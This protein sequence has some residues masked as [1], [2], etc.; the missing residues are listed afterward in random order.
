MATSIVPVEEVTMELYSYSWPLWVKTPAW[1]AA[2]TKSYNLKS[3]RNFEIHS[4]I[5]R[6]SSS[7]LSICALESNLEIQSI[8]PIRKCIESLLYQILGQNRSQI[9]LIR[10]KKN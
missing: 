2:K 1:A 6:K 7:L 5:L 4:V 8:L 10:N 9:E 3:D